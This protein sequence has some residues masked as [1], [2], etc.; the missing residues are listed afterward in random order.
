MHPIVNLSFKFY[1]VRNLLLA[2]KDQL[3]KWVWLNSGE[4]KYVYL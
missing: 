3:M 2:Q 1:Y 4:L